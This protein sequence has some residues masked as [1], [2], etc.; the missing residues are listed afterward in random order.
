MR[1][2]RMIVVVGQQGDVLTAGIAKCAGHPLVHSHV[3]V[4]RV[5]RGGHEEGGAVADGTPDSDSRALWHAWSSRSGGRAPPRA[6]GHRGRSSPES[7][8]GLTCA[9]RRASRISRLPSRDSRRR[10]QRRRLDAARARP[11]GAR[12][13]RHSCGQPAPCGACRNGTSRRS[14]VSAP[15]RAPSRRLR[16]HSRTRTSRPI[17]TYRGSRNTPRDTRRA[18]PPAR[19]RGSSRCRDSRGGSGRGIQ[20]SIQAYILMT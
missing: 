8:R 11:H 2:E 19:G 17:P 16:G 9:H 5:A 13:S 3:L 14:Q 10:A 15:R 1:R 6:Q 20:L 12:P 4:G 18:A 7:S